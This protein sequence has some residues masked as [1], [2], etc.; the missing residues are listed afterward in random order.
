[1][2]AAGIL[3]MFLATVAEIKS[4][5]PQGRTLEQ[6]AGSPWIFGAVYLIRVAAAA[7]I[8]LVSNIFSISANLL[9]IT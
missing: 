2:Y 4:K 7:I 6:R 8:L 9:E 1:M 3:N 5:L